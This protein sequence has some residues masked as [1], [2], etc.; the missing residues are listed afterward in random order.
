MIYKVMWSPWETF[1]L[2]FSSSPPPLFHFLPSFGQFPRD[3]ITENVRFS[4]PGQVMQECDV[5]VF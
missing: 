1:P 2:P 3:G 4:T 5:S